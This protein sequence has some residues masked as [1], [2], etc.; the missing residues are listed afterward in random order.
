LRANWAP[1]K[2]FILPTN[3][4]ANQIPH[5]SVQQSRSPSFCACAPPSVCRRRLASAG[6][7]PASPNNHHN[8]PAATITI[9]TKQ[10]HHNQ[11]RQPSQP[12]GN[13]RQQLFAVCCVFVPVRNEPSPHL[14]PGPIP[15]HSAACCTYLPFFFTSISTQFCF[16]NAS[17]STFQSFGFFGGSTSRSI[18]PFNFLVLFSIV[19]KF[20]LN[21]ISR[22]TIILL[23][24]SSIVPSF[25]YR[26]HPQASERASKHFFPSF[27]LPP[28]SSPSLPSFRPFPVAGSVLF[29]A[30]NKTQHCLPPSFKH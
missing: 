30:T 19:F 9:K 23:S 22:Q 1:N 20:S 24:F 6:H 21:F 14:F 28:L 29:T 11:W 4:F 25:P 27:F 26:Q 12:S 8:Q 3:S 2:H 18:F 7:W 17:T 15:L 5:F 13:H 10:N 16:N